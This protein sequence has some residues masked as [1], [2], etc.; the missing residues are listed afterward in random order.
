MALRMTFG[1][2]PCPSM[3]GFISATI[4]NVGNTIIHNDHWNPSKLHDPLS[5]ILEEPIPLPDNMEF[6]PAQILVVDMDCTRQQ[7]KYQKG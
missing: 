5:E 6:H 3:W 1:G 4:A 2:Y 7:R